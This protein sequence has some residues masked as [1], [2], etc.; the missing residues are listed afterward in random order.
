MELSNEHATP[1]YL[2]PF[3]RAGTV[4]TIL[5]T[6]DLQ[7]YGKAMETQEIECCIRDYLV[8]Q[9]IWE[10]ALDEE[11]VCWPGSGGIGQNPRSDV[12]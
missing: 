4:F 8:Y 9:D 7:R 11:L 5:S 12:E 6:F 1:K 3:A 2:V 10:A